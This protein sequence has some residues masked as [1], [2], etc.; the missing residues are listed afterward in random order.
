MKDSPM[1]DHLGGKAVVLT[2]ASTEAYTVAVM[3]YNKVDKLADNLANK[4]AASRAV[5]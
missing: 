5:Q 4:L 2:V 3:D 1:A